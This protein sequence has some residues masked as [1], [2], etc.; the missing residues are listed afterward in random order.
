MPP[1]YES[2][3]LVTPEIVA[4]A[5]RAGVEVH[6]WTVNDRREMRAMLDLGVDGIITDFPKRLLSVLTERRIPGGE[7]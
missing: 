2:W 3:R 7:K 5:H 4:Y 1:T 6:V